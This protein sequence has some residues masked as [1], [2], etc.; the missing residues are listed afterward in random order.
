[1]TDF[2]AKAHE[3]DPAYGWVM[4]FAVFLL[5]ALAFGA[6]GSIS[7]FSNHFRA[8]LVGVAVKPR[9]GTRS[10]LLLGLVRD[11]VGLYCRPLRYALV[12]P[13]RGACHVC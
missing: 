1:M 11:S 13:D 7:V 3:K 12:W 8:S 5:S 6:L 4:V 2:T 9:W 10:S